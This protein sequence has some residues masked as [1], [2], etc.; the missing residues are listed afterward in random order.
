VEEAYA[1]WQEWVGEVRKQKI[2]V[3]STLDQS[4]I[5]AVANGALR[6]LCPDDYAVSNIRRNRE[7][8]TE[9]FKRVTGYQMQIE[10]EISVEDSVSSHTLTP[11]HSLTPSSTTP[12]SSQQASPASPQSHPVLQALIRELG[13]E[14]V[15]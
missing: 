14:K 1:R 8:L 5:A 15:E 2:S 3:A 13:A 12:A 7:F 9:S 11:S 4:K 10:P 6:I